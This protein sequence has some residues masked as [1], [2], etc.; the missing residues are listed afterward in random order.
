M[1]DT[2][3]DPLAAQRAKGKAGE[4]ATEDE[5]RHGC[6]EVL[7]RHTQGDEGAEEAIGELDQARRHDQCPDLRPHQ[8]VSLLHRASNDD[9]LSS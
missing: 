8:P 5:T 2:L 7:D 6:P 4:V 1:P 3:D 9:C